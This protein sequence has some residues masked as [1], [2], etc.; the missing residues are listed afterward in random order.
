MAATSNLP[1]WPAVLHEEW[2]AAY[3]SLSTTTFRTA[4]V[5]EV[6]PIPLSAR[7]QGWRRT[8]LDAWIAKQAGDAAPLPGTSSW[9]DA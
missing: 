9:D 4:V 6:P 2:A 1:D 3:L 8:D 5:P 7:R